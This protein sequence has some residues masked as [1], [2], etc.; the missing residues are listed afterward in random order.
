LVGELSIVSIEEASGETISKNALE[1]EFGRGVARSID[2]A[3]RGKHLKMIPDHESLMVGDVILS[4]TSRLTMPE[5]HQRG[6]DRFKPADAVWSHAMLYVGRLHVVEF[7]TFNLKGLGSGIVVNPLTKHS[8]D[9]DFKICRR[10][11]YN[12]IRKFSSSRRGA[13]LYALLD[14]A[15]RRRRYDFNRIAA[16][17]SEGK[18]WE[19]FVKTMLPSDFERAMICSEFVLECLAINGLLTIDYLNLQQK[20]R[21]FLPADFHAHPLLDKLD[22]KFKVYTG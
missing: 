6:L 10:S 14:Q 4:K 18:K 5:W 3:L 8:A 13:A 17:A 19:A 12:T 1:S 15:V 16:I 21:Y 20:G 9:V 2:K 7:R 22:M 11:G